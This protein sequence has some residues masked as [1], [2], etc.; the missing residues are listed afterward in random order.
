MQGEFFEPIPE[1]PQSK[2]DY[3]QKYHD[4]PESYVG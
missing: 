3:Q 4:S 1:S 2:V